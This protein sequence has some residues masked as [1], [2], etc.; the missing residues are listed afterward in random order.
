MK[1]KFFTAVF[2]AMALVAGLAGPASAHERNRY[3]P[4]R[5]S[6]VLRMMDISVRVNGRSYDFGYGDR[7]FM[8]LIDRPYSFAPGLTYAYT[9]RCNRHGCVVFV[10]DDY[11]HRPVDRIFAPHLPFRGYAWRAARGFDQR[12]DD[13]G[14]Y[15]RNDRQF[16]QRWR[17]ERRDENWD[18]RDERWREHW[19]DDRHLDGGPSRR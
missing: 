11:R 18:D 19:N 14:A 13:Y 8:R 17:Y 12:Y 9:D 2:S 4:N 10:F 1:R 15:A 16:D 6:S 7:M 3:E 5:H